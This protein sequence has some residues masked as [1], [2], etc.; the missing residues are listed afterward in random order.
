MVQIMDHLGGFSRRDLVRGKNVM[1][2]FEV[3]L[4]RTQVTDVFIEAPD[5]KAIRASEV[6]LDM[7]NGTI[8]MYQWDSPEVCVNFIQKIDEIPSEYDL[9]FTIDEEGTVVGY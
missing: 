6:F 9:D 3:R 2:L 8:P 1:P 4:E 5:A 7:V